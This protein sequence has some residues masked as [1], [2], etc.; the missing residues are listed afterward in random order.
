MVK[1]G[2]A[3]LS[4]VHQAILE[5][6]LDASVVEREMMAAVF[7][8]RTEPFLKALVKDAGERRRQGQEALLGG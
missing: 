6:V 1:L 7:E 8:G 5:G 4:G 3:R 2:A